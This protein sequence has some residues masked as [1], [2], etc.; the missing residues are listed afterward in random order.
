MSKVKKAKGASSSAKKPTVVYPE[1]DVFLFKGNEPLSIDKAKELIGWEEE[2]NE[3]DFGT[4]Y[5]LCDL[6]GKKIRLNHNTTNRSFYASVARDWMLEILRRKWKLNGESIIIDRLGNVQDGQ[7]RFVG[8]ILA[9]QSLEIDTDRWADYWDCEPTIECLVVVGIDDSDDT[10]NTIGVGKPRSFADVIFRSEL[11][12]NK[13][14]I[15][16]L[17]AAKMLAHAVQYIWKRTGTNLVIEKSFLPKRSHSESLDF[18]QRHN[19]LEECVHVIQ[20][21]DTKN[22]VRRFIPPGYAVGMLYLMGSCTSDIDE[23][24]K[25]NSEE[26]LDWTLW[27]K[28]LKFWKGLAAGDTEFK[29]LCKKLLKTDSTGSLGLAMKC[30]MVIKGWNTYVDGHKITEDKVELLMTEDEFGQPTL[31][32]S[33]RCGGVDVGEQLEVG[34]DD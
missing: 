9:G 28:A 5:T 27:P 29:V 25:T 30:A 22:Q 24:G 11:F 17:E 12:R 19:R 21:M 10:V 4:E 16:R 14:K 13:P 33:P 23:Y 1:F 6:Y 8:L 2:V 32:E 18:L 15:R 7:H 20:E 26:S 3:G 34:E 31:G